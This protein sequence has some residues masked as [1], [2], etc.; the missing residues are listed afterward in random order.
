MVG[1][2][3]GCGGVGMEVVV[4]LNR[5]VWVCVVSLFGGCGEKSLLERYVFGGEGG[6]SC[7]C[8]FLGSFLDVVS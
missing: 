1:W 7:W 6:D 5:D 2:E 4:V 3:L 8:F